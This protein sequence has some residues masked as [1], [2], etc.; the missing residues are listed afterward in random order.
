MKYQEGGAPH[1]P[2]YENAAAPEGTPP[3]RIRD[4]F[5]HAVN[6]SNTNHEN[7]LWTLAEIF[8]SDPA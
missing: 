6:R 8:S 3:R 2:K 1:T 5:S 4:C 7:F